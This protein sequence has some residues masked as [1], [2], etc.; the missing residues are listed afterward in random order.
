V[1]YL[2]LSLKWSRGSDNFVWYRTNAAGY[3]IIIEQAGRYTADEA[4]KYSDGVTTLAVREDDALADAVRVVIN[5]SAR[6]ARWE[7]VLSRLDKSPPAVPAPTFPPTLTA[8]EA[9]CE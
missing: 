7:S 9:R 3:T 6:I 2:I 4:A 5:Y 8:G 1:K